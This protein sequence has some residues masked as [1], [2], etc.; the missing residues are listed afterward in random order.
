MTYLLSEYSS[1]WQGSFSSAR[2]R[3][4]AVSSIRLLVVLRS[5]PLISFSWGP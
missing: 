2:A 4:T 3:I 5:P 1:T